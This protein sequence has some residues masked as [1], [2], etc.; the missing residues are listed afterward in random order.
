MRRLSTSTASPTFTFIFESGVGS[1][2]NC[3]LSRAITSS[4]YGLAPTAVIVAVISLSSVCRSGLSSPRAPNLLLCRDRGCRRRRQRRPAPR[5]AGLDCRSRSCWRYGAQQSRDQ[6]HRSNAV[7][8]HR[9]VRSRTRAA[10]RSCPL[11]RSLLQLP[12]RCRTA[13]VANAAV[14][15]HRI[16]HVP[17]ISF[18]FRRL[19]R[20]RS[21][22]QARCA[23]PLRPRFAWRASTSPN[24]NSRCLRIHSTVECVAPSATSPCS[25][26]A[27]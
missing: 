8:A 19:R 27:T 6:Q 26:I 1:A 13:A 10:L 15:T 18:R 25:V 11:P 14:T 4:P 20:P 7:G 21:A 23:V 9:P 12:S 22:S 17:P 5:A 3:P 24:E 16:M 2:D